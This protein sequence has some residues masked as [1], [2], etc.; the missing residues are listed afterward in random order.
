MHGELS[1]RESLEETRELTYAYGEMDTPSHS[2]KLFS[3]IQQQAGISRR[4]AQDLIRSGEVSVDGHVVLDPFAP[5][6][7]GALRDVRLR[8]HPL[9]LE[10]PHLRVYRFHKPRSMLCSHDDPHEG[11][12]VGRVL[13]AEGFIGY[14]WAGRL[15]QDAEGL[16]LITN[17]GQLLHGLSH[18]RFEVLK[19]YHVWLRRPPDE[20]VMQRI[21]RRM[22]Q[23]VEDTG[24]RLCIREGNMTGSPPHPVVTLNEGRKREVKRLF[25][26][27]DL[28]VVRLRRT[29]LGTVHLGSLKPGA[30]DRL[31]EGEVERLRGQI[32]HGGRTSVSS[33]D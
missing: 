22:Q 30:W 4:K 6:A 12:T 7:S 21:F 15:D 23:G 32:P 29:I 16:L 14:S 13:R 26:S 2:R 19:T 31:A 24:D 20:N 11:N 17:D 18:P 8:G 28:E 3:V 25:A 5:G 33:S 9:S 1:N 10:P 27:F